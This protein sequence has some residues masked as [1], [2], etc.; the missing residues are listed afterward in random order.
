MLFVCNTVKEVMM[1]VCVCVCIVLFSFCFCFIFSFVYF[2]IDWVRFKLKQ[3]SP[4]C[5]CAGLKQLL[6]THTYTQVGIRRNA[7]TERHP[8]KLCHGRAKRET[9][10][11]ARSLACSEDE[12]RGAT[13]DAK[14]AKTVGN[15]V[16]ASIDG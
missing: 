12:A 15:G 8:L 2:P 9:C 3:R 7:R 6:H 10:A 14:R 5:L 4:L 1:Y 13:H 11:R 16:N